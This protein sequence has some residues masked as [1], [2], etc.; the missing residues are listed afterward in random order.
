MGL[1]TATTSFP[2]NFT[3]LEFSHTKK[4]NHPFNYVMRQLLLGKHQKKYVSLKYMMIGITI[5]CYPHHQKQIEDIRITKMTWT[6]SILY[7][8]MTQSILIRIHLVIQSWPYLSQT[9]LPRRKLLFTW[10][11]KK[12]RRK[13]QSCSMNTNTIGEFKVHRWEVLTK[14]N[15]VILHLPQ[16]PFYNKWHKYVWTM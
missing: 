10:E 16:K 12:I 7:T 14:L 6:R 5:P 2:E 13:H 11:N 15:N 8:W 4:S 1:S 9:F 3:N